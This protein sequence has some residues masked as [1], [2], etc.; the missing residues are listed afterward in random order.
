MS[1]LISCSVDDKHIL[2]F[3]ADKLIKPGTNIKIEGYVKSQNRGRYHN[4][5][6]T[7]INRTN[8]S[9]VINN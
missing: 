8:I 7:I 4:G 6:E 9:E 3:F 1:Y 5:I 2:K